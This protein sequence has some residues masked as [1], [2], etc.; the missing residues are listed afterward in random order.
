MANKVWFITGISR[1]LGHALAQAAL[2][3]GDRVIGT[4]R[5]GLA[6][7]GLS[8]EKL[9]VLP[10]E[11]GDAA[12]IERAMT[13]AFAL[14]GRIDVLV[15]NAGYGLIGPVEAA[16]DEEVRRNF[17]IN[18]FGPLAILR[19]ALPRMRAQGRGHIVNISSIAGIAPG[20]GSGI[21][22]GTKAALWAIS[23]ALSQELAPFGLW[24][25]SV[26]PG[27]FRTD[28][29]SGRSM[30]R[31]AAHIDGYAASSG[32]AVD[33]LL[34]KDG[35]QI[36]APHRAALAILAAVDADEPPLDLLLGSDALQRAQIRLDRFDDD[37]RRWEDVS[38]G[39]DF[40]ET[41]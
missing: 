6:P 37:R 35:K 34:D 15:N 19:H 32:R 39:T 8:T 30:L 33:T 20:A 4:T 36:G 13:A 38:R 29:L 11:A 9:D 25:T 26:E 1:G 16:S 5:E 21:Y 17:E 22:A 2:E 31:T 27:S 12:S 10:L 14:H 3:R 41:A 40:P 18:V 24:V 7:E 28:F 23:S